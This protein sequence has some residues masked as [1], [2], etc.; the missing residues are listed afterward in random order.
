[1]RIERPAR[2]RVPR[3][4]LTPLIDVVF[5]LLVFFIIGGRFVDESRIRLGTVAAGSDPPAASGDAPSV[6][7][8]AIESEAV[9]RLA[10]RQ[11]GFEAI[12]EQL[13]QA[14][15]RHPDLQIVLTPGAA[16]DTQALVDAIDRLHGAGFVRLAYLAE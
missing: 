12:L 7:L 10:G 13:A 4:G 9:W 1:M 2:R 15:G 14:R 11:A 16:L 5:L 6:M 3:V 8:L